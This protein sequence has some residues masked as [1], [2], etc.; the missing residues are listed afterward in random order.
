MCIFIC[1]IKKKYKY[2]QLYSKWFRI[3]SKNRGYDSMG[4][5]YLD[6]NKEKY[7]IEKF[8][9]KNTSDCFLILKDLFLSE[10][11]SLILH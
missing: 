8:A 5:C 11:I 7:I 4:I 3:N 1:F 2:Y 9:S 6:K 10:S